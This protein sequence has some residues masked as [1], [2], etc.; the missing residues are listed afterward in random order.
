MQ[1]DPY[2]NS[3]EN[4][5]GEINH[6]SEEIGSKWTQYM[7]FLFERAEYMK[8]RMTEEEPIALNELD[9]VIKQI[10]K[11]FEEIESNSK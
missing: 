7:V 8:K 10:N 4:P 3:E 9:E 6:S 5:I 1:S 2:I 11:K